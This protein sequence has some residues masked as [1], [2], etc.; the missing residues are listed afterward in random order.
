M[1]E[2]TDSLTSHAKAALIAALY[3]SS[4][5]WFNIDD[6]PWSTRALW[7]SGLAF[8]VGSI[9][10]ATQ[11]AITLY[12]FSSQEDACHRI[13][14]VL[15]H[16]NRHGRWR[17]KMMHVYIWQVPVICLR[18]G[19]L[20]FL[21]GL[22]ILLWTA[23]L[24]SPGNFQVSARSVVDLHPGLTSSV[25]VAVVFSVVGPLIVLNY[26]FCSFAVY[27]NAS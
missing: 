15:G 8:T 10:S 24:D 6:S 7:F 22:I 4:F 2:P 9:S 19:I 26:L 16:R 20:L 27:F 14:K 13:R 17:P 18:V 21:I 23:K 11:Q 5:S 3:G 25:Q 1:S 12:R